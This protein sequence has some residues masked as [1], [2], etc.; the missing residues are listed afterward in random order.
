VVGHTDIGYPDSGLTLDQM[1]Y[2]ADSRGGQVAGGFTGLG[3]GLMSRRPGRAFGRLRILSASAP[4]PFEGQI[5]SAGNGR[6]DAVFAWETD[7]TSATY[8]VYALVRRRNGKVVGP[9][10]ISR[11]DDPKYAASP[12]VGI[13]GAGRALV[14]YV[15]QAAERSQLSRS[16]IRVSICGRR[17]GFGPVTSI[18]GPSRTINRDPVV[19]VNLRGQAAVW[20]S[21]E[22][23]LPDGNFTHHDVLVRGRLR[24]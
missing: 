1:A 6:G 4:A 16:Q 12:S 20:F 13:D 2:V 18:T 5:V 7:E 22:T 14:A 17:R 8:E 9:T 10:L 21:H 19:V 11:G 3:F 23:E 24:R 15:A